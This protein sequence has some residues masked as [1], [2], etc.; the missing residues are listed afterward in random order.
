MF[1]DLILLALNVVKI[2]FASQRHSSLI[3]SGEY[4]NSSILKSRSVSQNHQYVSNIKSSF[5]FFEVAIVAG[6]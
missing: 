3:N 5:Y 6:F 4:H 2:D 1:L